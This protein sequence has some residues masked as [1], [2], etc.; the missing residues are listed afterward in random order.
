LLVAVVLLLGTSALAQ[1]PLKLGI[2]AGLSFYDQTYDIN[3]DGASF[4]PGT[5]TGFSVGLMGDYAVTPLLAVRTELSYVQKGSKT[6]AEV[7]ILTGDPPAFVVD[8]FVV[9]DR[10]DYVSASVIGRFSL[11]LLDQGFYLLAGPRLDVRVND[12]YTI[13]GAIDEERIS[14]GRDYE[15]TVFGATLGLGYQFS[16]GPLPK[17]FVAADYHLDFTDA[18]TQDSSDPEKVGSPDYTIRN[19]TILV[20]VGMRF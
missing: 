8:T 20:T 9:K 11:P 18:F 2:K 15:S 5:G 4:D 17:V 14:T 16:K 13:D 10:V 19:R 6:Q 3:V 7:F 1:T 12:E